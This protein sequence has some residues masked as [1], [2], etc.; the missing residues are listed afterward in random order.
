M[1][2][3]ATR[4]NYQLPACRSGTTY[5]LD[6]SSPALFFQYSVVPLGSMDPSLTTAPN[7]M[8][9]NKKL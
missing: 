7:I 8:A 6:I 9:G 2:E 5:Q 3:I 4:K 1:Y